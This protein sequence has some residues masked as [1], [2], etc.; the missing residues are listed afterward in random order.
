MAGRY[1]SLDY[2]KLT[3]RGFLLGLGLF[4]FGVTAEFAIG[5]LG[6]QVPAWEEVLLLD[7]IGLGIVVALFSVLVF[8]IVLPLTE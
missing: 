3:K 4:I 7:A 8:G 1:G 2:P 6:L 5:V